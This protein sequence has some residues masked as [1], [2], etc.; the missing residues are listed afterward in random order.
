[1]LAK[2]GKDDQSAP[3][4]ENAPPPDIRVTTEPTELIVTDGPPNFAPLTGTQL[5]YVTNTESDVFRDIQSQRVFVVI[6]GRW[7]SAPS[8]RGPLDLRPLHRAALGVRRHSRPGHRRRTCWPTSPAPSRPRKPSSTRRFPQTAAIKRDAPGPTV[9]YDGQPDFQPV[10]GTSMTYAVNTPSSVLHIQGRYYSVRRRRLV[11]RPRPAGAVDGGRRH[12]ARHPADSAVEP[13]LQREVRHRVPGHAGGGVRRLHPGLPRQ[14][15]LERGGGLRHRLVLPPL[16]LARRLRAAPADLGPPRQLQRRGADGAT[17]WG[18]RRDSSGTAP[19]GAARTTGRPGVRRGAAAGTA[20]AVTGPS[21]AHRRGRTRVV[22]IPPRPVY[23]Y[24]PRPVGNLYARPSVVHN[25][26]GP[27]PVA[28]VAAPRP[29]SPRP[30]NRLPN[31]VYTDRDGN[32]YRHDNKGTWQ[33]RD[34]QA[35]KPAPMPTAPGGGAVTR[36]VPTSPS[37]PVTR[38]VPTTPGTPRPVGPP[39]PGGPVAKP[40]PITP[41]PAPAQSARPAPTP[42]EHDYR[43]RVAG[44]Q[45]AAELRP[46]PASRPSNRPA[47]QHGAKPEKR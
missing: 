44:N 16:R 26:V 47:P 45:R 17:A 18:G 14:L 23:A 36:P 34:R 11:R 21:I 39:T 30:I 40:T 29:V 8:L 28:S 35:W 27:R 20:P 7:Y 32:I 3:A 19:T 43:A 42:I 13:G 38:P 31:N 46:T 33:Q 4:P 1:M 9:N 41:R 12:A 15:R 6:S 25:V 22:R 2:G 5:L 37:G 24:P 10:Q